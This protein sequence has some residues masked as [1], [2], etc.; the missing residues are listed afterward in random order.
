MIFTHVP[1]IAPEPIAV[2]VICDFLRKPDVLPVELWRYC[3]MQWI[4]ADYAFDPEHYFTNEPVAD[5]VDED[6]PE[7]DIDTVPESD[8]DVVDDPV[9][10]IDEEDDEG[11]DPEPDT[12]VLSVEA[13]EQ[14]VLYTPYINA[15]K[16]FWTDMMIFTEDVP[17]IKDWKSTVER[18]VKYVGFVPVDRARLIRHVQRLNNARIEAENLKNQTHTIQKGSALYQIYTSNV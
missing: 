13:R 15:L 11:A 7:D 18:V 4:A 3:A 17:V 8:A 5:A 9:A 14:I 1:T 6:V 2:D 12:S 16:R 10:V